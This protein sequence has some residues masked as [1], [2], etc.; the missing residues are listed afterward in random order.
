MV[1]I[2]GLLDHEKTWH[3]TLQICPLHLSDVATFPCE[4]Q[5]SHS[6]Q[7]NS[8]IPLIRYVISQ[9]HKL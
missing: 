1:M 7:Y 5:K 9:D 4:I 2:F 8:Y 6:E 3:E